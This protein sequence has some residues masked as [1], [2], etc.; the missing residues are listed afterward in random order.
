M[1]S[2]PPL[3]VPIPEVRV[4]QPVQ[5]SRLHLAGT[6]ITTPWFWVGNDQRKPDQL[7]LPLDVLI[8]GLGFQRQQ[9]R[10]GELLEWYGQKG[11]LSEL[12]QRTID[13]EVG[14]EVSQWLRNLGVQVNRASN[15][16]VIDFPP[17][18]VVR[19]RRGKGSTA[20]RLVLDLNRAALVQRQGS[21]LRLGISVT[22]SQERQLRALGLKPRR[23]SN[24]LVLEG[25]ST[26]L[27]TLTL[28][29][30]WRVVLDGVSTGT[31]KPAGRD[32]RDPLAA[33]LLNPTIQRL[34]RRGLILDRRVVKVGVKS[35][36]IYRIGANP[37]RQRL[38]LR[39]LAPTHSQQG[40][41]YLTQLS[42]PAGALMSVNGG[43][44]NRVRQL[45]LGAVKRDGTWLSGP[46]LN[47]GAVGWGADNRLQFGRLRLHQELRVEGGPP[48]GLGYLNSGY[49]QRGLSRYDRA[50]GPVY[51][52][53]SSQEKAMTVIN[54]QVRSTHDN[55]ALSRGVPIPHQGDLIVARAGA[56]LPAQFGQRVAIRSTSSDPLGNQPQVLGGGPLLLKGGQVV[57]NGRGEGFRD[58]FLSQGA[59]RTV[60]AQDRTR[61][62]LLTLEGAGNS[63]P[64]LLESSL[65]LKQLGIS[66]ALNLD[67]GSS[68]SLFV[69]NQLVMT[70][71]G[72]APRV[73]NAV[74]LVPR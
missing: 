74:G 61:L 11:L 40:L 38:D 43:F 6:E 32:G 53:L 63:D 25:Q 51:R 26:M 72:I 12:P 68:T 28:T 69:A 57:L 67:G 20:N 14:I 3:P 54:G 41:R 60:I 39:P 48:W 34:L 56:P 19:L 55:A 17:A 47:R 18:T 10:T 4:A 64:T 35:V 16:L 71:R 23:K 50:W 44:F 27:S 62:W 8:G 30:P 13:D 37:T 24:S 21:D 58:G 2:P 31:A 65:A 1:V 66:D 5:G 29:A 36:M 7:W 59:P 46:I 15:G 42:Q 33:A 9:S 49:V 70:G 22:P 45:P 52:A 73:Q